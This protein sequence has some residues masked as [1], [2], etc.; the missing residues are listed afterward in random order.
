MLI[1]RHGIRSPQPQELPAMT[2]ALLS[3]ITRRHFLQAGAAAAAG[4]A[5][6]P[7]VQAA[8]NKD[9]FGGFIVGAQS[10]TFREFDTEQALKRIQE[11]GLRHVEFYQK[12]ANPKSTPEQIKSLLKMCDDFG[13]K[14]VA[15]G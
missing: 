3:G 12:H 7:A 10:Y 13:I 5:S 8:Q 9:D 6:W 2:H 1:Q 15:F 14:P 4:L 11:A